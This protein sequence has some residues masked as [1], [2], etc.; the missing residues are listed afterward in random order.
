MSGL[1]EWVTA[2]D[3]EELRR[4][5]P[6]AAEFLNVTNLR[7]EYEQLQ[8]AWGRQVWTAEMVKRARELAFFFEHEVDETFEAFCWRKE[9][10]LVAFDADPSGE[11]IRLKPEEIKLYYEFPTEPGTFALQLQDGRFL[12]TRDNI[13]RKYPGLRELVDA[14]TPMGG[15]KP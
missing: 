15:I 11:R 6:D 14:Q 4:L 13:R 7:R 9:Y 1:L 2:E 3:L 5:W 12:Y 8:A 10:H